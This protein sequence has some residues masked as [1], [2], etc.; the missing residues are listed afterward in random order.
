MT[1][2]ARD[3]MGKPWCSSG[4]YLDQPEACHFCMASSRI[5]L[6]CRDVEMRSLMET[7]A[8]SQWRLLAMSSGV[9]CE[10]HTTW[11]AIDPLT[12]S[13]STRLTCEDSRPFKRRRI[14][15]PA[16]VRSPALLRSR[17]TDFPKCASTLVTRRADC[18]VLAHPMRYT[19]RIEKKA[20]L[21]VRLP[22]PCPRLL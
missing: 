12:S 17:T 10:F 5:Q 8:R 22:A 19:L 21:N 14:L 16:V 11:R 20:N 7:L 6:W 1:G 18:E 2:L 15:D 4:H 13:S 9:S 3:V